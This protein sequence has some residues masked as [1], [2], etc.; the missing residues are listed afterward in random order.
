MN[1]AEYKGVQWFILSYDASKNLYA[2]INEATTTD[3]A[4]VAHLKTI[5]DFREDIIRTLRSKNVIE[6]SQSVESTIIFCDK[7]DS[8]ITE[9]LDYWDKEFKKYGTAEFNYVIAPLFGTKYYSKPVV[10]INPKESLNNS[11]LD[12]LDKF[13]NSE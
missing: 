10:K 11:F 13:L 5:H 8:T 1:F 9:K 7:S 6:M 4:I 3:A 2:L 12:L